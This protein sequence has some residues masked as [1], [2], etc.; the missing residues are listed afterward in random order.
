MGGLGEKALQSPGSHVALPFGKKE[1][2]RARGWEKEKT[3]SVL[4]CYL[5]T[6]SLIPLIVLELI[7]LNSLSPC[8]RPLAIFWK[9]FQSPQ[10]GKKGGERGKGGG[11]GGGGERGKN[12]G[13][14][15][16]SIQ[17]CCCQKSEMHI[18][19]LSRWGCTYIYVSFL[20]PSRISVTKNIGKQAGCVAYMESTGWG[21]EHRWGLCPLSVRCPPSEA[22]G[23]GPRTIGEQM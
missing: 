7:W 22:A 1:P 5:F 16:R 20:S 17:Q 23:G 12:R 2:M 4:F 10:H 3:S 15:R 14:K 13:H 19:C 21:G 9:F 6:L 18:F 8:E 11:G